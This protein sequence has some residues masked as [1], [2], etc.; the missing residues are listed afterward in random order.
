MIYFVGPNSAVPYKYCKTCTMEDVARYCSSKKYLGVDT[1]TEGMDFLV[2]KMIMFQIGDKEHQF[3]I[4]DFFQAL[5]FIIFLV[6][7]DLSLEAF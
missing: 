5:D 3:V 1:E 4:D 2:K 7:F 6:D